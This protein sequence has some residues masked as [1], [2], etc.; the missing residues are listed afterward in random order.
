MIGSAATRVARSS[1][2]P[3]SRSSSARRASGSASSGASSRVIDAYSPIAPGV[4]WR[5]VDAM[6]S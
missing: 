5:T 2:T 4:K 1:G 6:S 3:R